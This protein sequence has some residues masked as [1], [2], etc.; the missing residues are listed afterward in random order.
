MPEQ[1][2]VKIVAG[3]DVVLEDECRQLMQ[4]F[5]REKR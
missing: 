5:F 3:D 1:L 4:D 2:L